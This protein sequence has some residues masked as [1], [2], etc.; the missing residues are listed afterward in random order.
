MHDNELIQ[1]IELIQKVV[2][3]E[4]DKQREASLAFERHVSKMLTKL[5]VDIE[6]ETS[7]MVRALEIERLKTEV[8]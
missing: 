3:D 6:M 4:M 2:S 1:R 5:S 7:H 8:I